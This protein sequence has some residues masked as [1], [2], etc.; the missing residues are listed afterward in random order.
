MTLP[1][2]GTRQGL[3]SFSSSAGA[4]GQDRGTFRGALRWQG[5]RIREF[6]ST[7]SAMDRQFSFV[8]DVPNCAGEAQ[9][10]PMG[11]LEGYAVL[12]DKSLAA[13]AI[14]E[15]VLEI[16]QWLASD[17]SHE[18][19]GAGL[20]ESLGAKLGK[21]GVPIHRVVFHLRALHPTVMGRSIAWAPGE[22]ATVMDIAHGEGGT[23][24]APENPVFHV[25]STRSWLVLRTDDRRWTPHPLVQGHR[26]SE[27]VIAPMIHGPDPRSVSAVTFGTRR[28]AGFT[29]DDRALLHRVV[30]ALRGAIELKMWHRTTRTLLD[31][32]VGRDAEK[33]IL[34]GQI[35]R[36]E[37]ESLEA[38]LM[39]CD[40]RD[41]TALSNRLS[42]ERVLELLNIYFDQVVPVVTEGG[43]KILKFMGDGV[44]AFFRDAARPSSSCAAAFRAARHVHKRLAA[45]SV[46]DA[47]LRAGIALHFGKVS[48]GNIGSSERLD[49]TVIGRD[50]NLASRIEGLCG[51]TSQP[52]LMSER[53]AGLL[54]VPGAVSIGWHAIKGF[55]EPVQ[56]F[57]WNDA[58]SPAPSFSP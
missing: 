45:T 4:K 16:I 42:G 8:S 24:D 27:L 13:S 6:F 54:A 3:P 34:S 48:Y 58:S 7:E 1:S 56:L 19:D 51:P 30:P 29:R 33:R 12:L 20:I 53:F 11:R 21:M 38:A 17:R 23:S 55:V 26:L 25:L 5:K 57:A 47:K 39:F 44:L 18:L 22:P 10:L 2:T 40:L 31:T 35:R 37:V 9:T 43:G 14:D 49:F 15:N 52:L 41:F 36:G 46:P 32:Y 28:P 50:V